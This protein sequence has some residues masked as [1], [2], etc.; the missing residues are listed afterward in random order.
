MASSKLKLFVA[1]FVLCSIYSA[2]LEYSYAE[3][4][5]MKISELVY[6]LVADRV[7]S[8][9]GKRKHPIYKRVRHHS[10]LDLAAP[11]GAHV[12]AVSSGKVVFAGSYRGYGKLVTLRHGDKYTS[13]Y[14]HLDEL[15]VNIGDFVSA[16]EVIGK[17]GST[18][19]STG[20]H[21]HFEWHKQGKAVNPLEIL[22]GISSPPEG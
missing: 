16:G 1:F 10:G 5:S 3:S 21:L 20:P 18:G 8:G 22:P 17:V 15:L 13:L 4:S 7:S 6:P 2:K 11:K 12:R 14:G 9:F 19:N